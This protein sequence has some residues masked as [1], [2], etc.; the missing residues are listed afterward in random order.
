M[1]TDSRA[2]ALPPTD[3][4]PIVRTSAGGNRSLWIFAGL[5]LVAAALLF[6]VATI[7]MARLTDYISKKDRQRRLQGVL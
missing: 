4:R 3:V 6:L 2:G 5:L 1:T 7:P